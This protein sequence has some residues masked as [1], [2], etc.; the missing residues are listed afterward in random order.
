MTVTAP[1]AGEGA[2]FEELERRAFRLV[3][4]AV[5]KMLGDAGVRKALLGK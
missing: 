5:I 2:G 4:A 3:D 1:P